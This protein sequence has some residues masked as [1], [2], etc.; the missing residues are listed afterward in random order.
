MSVQVGLDGSVI[1]ADAEQV[2]L[3]VIGSEGEMAM[4]RKWLSTAALRAA[5]QW[6]FTPPTTG[7]SAAENS[8]LVRVPVDFVLRDKGSNEAPK[9]GGWDSYVPGPRNANMPWAREQLKMAGSPDALSEGGV[10]S[11][12]EGATLLLVPT[13]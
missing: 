8:W 5:K 9:K 1:Q 7:K 3:R 4:M 13:T 11:L 6:I 2:N 10:Y 12:Q